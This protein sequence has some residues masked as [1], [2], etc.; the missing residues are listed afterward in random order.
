MKQFTFILEFRGGTYIS[1][2]NTDT[3]QIALTKWADNLSIDSIQYFGIVSKKELQKLM[4]KEIPTLIHGMNNVWCISGI[5]KS[6]F[7][8]TTIVAA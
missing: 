8:I 5:L 7:F 2:V 6:G 4:R 3:I 1:Q